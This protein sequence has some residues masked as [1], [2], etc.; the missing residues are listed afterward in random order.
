MFRSAKRTCEKETEPNVNTSTTSGAE[1]HL[2]FPVKVIFFI[3]SLQLT[4]NHI[5]SLQVT[6]FI[7]LLSLQLAGQ[8]CLNNRIVP[9]RFIMLHNLNLI[10]VQIY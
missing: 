8:A 6:G 4:L 3:V 9:P 7:V 5:V 10:L 1:N 2:Y